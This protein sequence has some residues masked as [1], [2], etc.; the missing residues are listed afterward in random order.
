MLRTGIVLIIVIFIVACKASHSLF[1][2]EETDLLKARSSDSHITLEDLK[3]GYN[4]YVSNCSGCHSLNRPS[5]KN[6]QEWEKLLPVM[7]S[8]TQLKSHEQK[9]VRE[10]IVSKL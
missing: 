9:L 3:S 2:P 8:K 7:F 4:L 1:V 5:S 6:K 10:Y